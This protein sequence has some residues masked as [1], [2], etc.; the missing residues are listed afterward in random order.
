MDLLNAAMGE[1]P[2]ELAPIR[3]FQYHFF[4][5][6]VGAW[7]FG[8]DGK[9][10]LPEFRRRLLEYGLNATRE[11]KESSSWLN[12][13]VDYESALTQT[14]GTLLDNRFFLEEVR[15]FCAKIERAA[16]CN[17]L[18]QCLLRFASPGVPDTYQG[19]EL[20]HQPLPNPDNRQSVDFGHRQRLLTELKARLGERGALVRDLLDSFV[21]GRVKLFV[22]HVVLQT[23]K[24]HPELF[25]RGDY[26]AIAG[27]GH[28]VA[29][30][31][32]FDTERLICCVP[33]LVHELTNAGDS[34]PLGS[35]W[36]NTEL[37]IHHTGTY[38]N[39]FTGARLT[40][41]RR[42]AVAELLAEFPIALLMKEET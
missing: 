36:G 33:R 15:S 23:R 1:V 38:T 18:S 14:L 24:Q 21:D 39:V 40:V 9:E 3:T 32:G 28:L 8:W 34:W 2:Q 26:E 42:L 13:N 25:L 27:N 11:A 37:P 20:W 29:F 12:P 35:I 31:R 5:A 4:Q 22:T 6:M 41:S 30:T 16:A 19:A 7:P 17:A 10:G